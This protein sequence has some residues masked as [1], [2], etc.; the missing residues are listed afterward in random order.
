M[1]VTA[2]TKV[3]TRRRIL[4]VAG[5][6]FAADGYEASTT[7]D[8]ANAAGIANGTLFNYFPN[9]EAVLAALVA[10]TADEIHADFAKHGPE[11][12]SFEE[13]LF[14]F[15]AAGLRKL[16]SWRKHLPVLLETL[17]QPLTETPADDAA[18]LRLSHLEMVA[19]LAR[20]H[21]LGELP[22]V[23]LQLYWT[24]YLGV[25]MFW[26]Q[27]RSPKQEDTLALLDSSLAMFTGWLQPE[28]PCPSQKKEEV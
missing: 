20:Q 23:A 9:K 11:E 6:L 21:G 28:K 10:E 16:K 14:A 25:L 2:E 26:A 4:E 5:Q 12:G 15:V 8:I 22:A 27:D 24:L 18:A 7:R 1:R 3:Q 13:A 19:Q 17:L